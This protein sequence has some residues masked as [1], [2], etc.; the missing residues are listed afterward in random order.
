MFAWRIGLQRLASVHGE[1]IAKRGDAKDFW[2]VIFK[3]VL[4]GKP[5]PNHNLTY[6]QW[7]QIP[8]RQIRLDELVL[9]ETQTAC[10]VLRRRDVVAR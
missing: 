6:R 4:D 7:A 3:G 2:L 8:P 9:W 10:A 1:A 5:Y